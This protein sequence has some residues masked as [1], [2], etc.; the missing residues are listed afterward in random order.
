MANDTASYELLQT[1]HDL[2][3]RLY[4]VLESGD[5]SALRPLLEERDELIACL[6]TM[7]KPLTRSA[8]WETL[9]ASVASQHQALLER[10]RRIESRMAETLSTMGRYNQAR[11]EYHGSP[12]TRRSVLGRHVQG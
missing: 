7:P 2:G 12:P 9:A 4:D 8:E 6:R 1:V 10:L 11:Q 5:L 3:D